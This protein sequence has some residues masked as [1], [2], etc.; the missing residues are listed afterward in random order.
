MMA[1]GDKIRILVVRAWT[2]PLAPLRA[3]LCDA[4][5]DAFITR[6]DIEPALD[7]ALTRTSFDVIVFDPATPGITRD[8]VEARL[9]EHRC[10]TPVVA[11]D[12]ASTVIDRIK[13]ALANR[14][15]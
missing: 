14:L 13:H 4:G 1:A 6:V 7:A 15:N 11:L 3:A 12:N 8:I 5:I 9:C 2:R 10:F